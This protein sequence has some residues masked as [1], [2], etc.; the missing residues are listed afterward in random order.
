M[1]SVTTSKKYY[2]EID[3]ARGFVLFLTVFA[4]A[5]PSH[6][7]WFDWISSFVMQTFFFL[8]GMTFKPDRFESAGQ[9]LKVKFRKRIIPYFAICLVGLTICLIRPDYRAPLFDAGWSYGLTWLLYYAQPRN[10]YI[11]Q[12]WFL[13]CL[14][15]AEVIF[16]LWYKI[17]RRAHPLIK[18]YSVIVLAWAAM[19]VP[20]VNQMFFS[21]MGRMPWKI[22]AA[23]GAA[24]FM[25]A[26]Y[27]AQKY[28]VLGRLS[29]FYLFLMPLFVY[30]NYILGPAAYGY[31]NVCDCV[32][33]PWLYYYSASFLGTFAV[34]LTA[35]QLKHWRFWQFVGHYSLPLFAAQTLFIYLVIETI[36]HFTGVW[37]DPVTSDKMALAI[38]VAAFILMLLVIWPYHLWKTGRAKRRAGG[39][40]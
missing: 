27:Y 15:F 33:S 1:N 9:F 13:V 5:L 40:S 2:S 6:Q 22:D 28:D 3:V 34:C 37:Q 20:A 10:L 31:V 8:S 4:H 23:L 38:A 32:Y 21:S 18:F 12:V 24:V 16:Y 36:Y 25:I 7:L 26:G 17:F 29:R 35:V 14:F 11:G 30:A 19:K 39:R